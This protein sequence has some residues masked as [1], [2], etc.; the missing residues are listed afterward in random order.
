M[1]G[2]HAHPISAAPRRCRRWTPG[3]G[4]LTLFQQPVAAARTVRVSWTPRFQEQGPFECGTVAVP[5]DYDKP[6][7]ATISIALVRLP[8]ADPSR[9]IGSLF[10]NP[11]GPGGSGVDFAVLA[12]PSLFTQEV[13]DHF[14]LVGFD[15]RGIARST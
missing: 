2:Q 8:A 13:R 5:L 1:G 11:G 6:R 15:P 7:G 12:G 10:L 3:L 4:A 9:R 14:D